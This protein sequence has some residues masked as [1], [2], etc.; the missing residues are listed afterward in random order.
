MNSTPKNRVFLSCMF[1][2][3]SAPTARHSST[4]GACARFCAIDG[5]RGR[6][7]CALRSC[8]A[9]VRVCDGG[10]GRALI[11]VEVVAG[12]LGS[13]RAHLSAHH[14]RAGDG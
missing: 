12:Q 8:S 1:L 4:G 11:R 3:I 14:G 6:D 7:S 13:A 5:R 9:L 10:G 2:K